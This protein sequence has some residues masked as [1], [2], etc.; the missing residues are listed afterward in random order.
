MTESFLLFFL[1]K[2]DIFHGIGLQ[3]QRLQVTL[4]LRSHGL[5]RAFAVVESLRR[6]RIPLLRAF[7][8]ASLTCPQEWYQP[9]S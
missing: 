6:P 3:A 2:E 8:V 7:R 1:V 9:L 5:N 4:R